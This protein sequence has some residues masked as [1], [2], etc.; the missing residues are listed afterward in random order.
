MY[1]KMQNMEA[2]K[3]QLVVFISDCTTRALVQPD[4]NEIAIIGAKVV[5]PGQEGGS[6]SSTTTSNKVVHF[7][8]DGSEDYGS[9][10]GADA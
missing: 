7:D 6:D 3:Q 1:F 10:T 4:E 5:S 9:V 8:K 2:K